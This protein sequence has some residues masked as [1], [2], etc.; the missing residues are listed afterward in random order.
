MGKIKKMLNDISIRKSFVLY[1]LIFMVLA[2]VF[3]GISLRVV[4][5]AIDNINASYFTG[6]KERYYLTTEDGK[7]LGKGAGIIE[8]Y[9]EPDYSPQD[10]QKILALGVIQTII[11]PLAY[12]LCTVVAAMLFYRNKLR[13]P[14]AA[15]N[16]ASE[17]IA[18][19]DLDFSVE[20][21]STDEMGK[22]CAS[23][24]KMRGALEKNNR[25]MWRSVEERKRL[26]AAFAHDLRTPL[27][28]LSGYT[29]FLSTHL[30]EDTVP[31]EKVISTVHTMRGQISRL[32]SYVQNLNSIQRLEEIKPQPQ[33]VILSDIQQ[34]FQEISDIVRGDK[35]VCFSTLKQ[36]EKP[37]S[38]DLDLLLQV[39][40]NL[41]SNA[42]RYAE[43]KIDVAIIATDNVLKV[44]VF[45]DGEGFSAEAVKKAAE[46]F[47]RADGKQDKLHFGLGLYICKII[48]E[49]H[50]G[51]LLVSNG[52]NGGAFITATFHNSN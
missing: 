22:L 46:P 45:D 8:Q 40:E 51:G 6:Q 52:S 14:L 11:S 35:T 42:I 49:K 41:I 24:E 37:I 4:N 10:K 21:D 12:L 44:T 33:K 30:V 50:G 13:T 18:T 36:E 27:T 15:L 19:D 3:S 28:V 32:E 17:K 23:F 34:A 20:Y 39:F 5:I 7:Q 2:I 43:N 1:M 38:I 16:T 9:V 26:N 25:E 31:K 48:C 29:E 47:Y